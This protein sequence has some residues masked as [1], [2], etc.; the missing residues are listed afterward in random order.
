MDELF[1]QLETS[2]LYFFR[3]WPNEKTR[4][5]AVG[6]YTIW[7]EKQFIYVGISTKSLF[8]RLRSHAS[9][10]RSGDQ[11]CIYVSDRFILPSLDMDSIKSISSGKLL[12]DQLMRQYIQE[13][14]SY[15]FIEVQNVAIASSIEKR[16]KIA[17][18]K[19]GLPLLNA[20]ATGILI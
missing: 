14:L 20:I 10:R 11:F 7:E 16:I 18:L 12:M 19:V 1:S 9:G 6:V 5:V 15:R 13:R 8:S 2:E 4:P 17:G 3:D